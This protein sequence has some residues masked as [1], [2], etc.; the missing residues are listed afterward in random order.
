[1]E[2]NRDFFTDIT[3]QFKSGAKIFP[4]KI[5]LD[6]NGV[7]LDYQAVKRTV[8]ADKIW[9]IIAAELLKYD[10]TRIIYA[11]RG[12]RLV[13]EA[14]DKKVNMRHEDAL[15]DAPQTSVV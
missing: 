7:T 15:A 11:E 6:E 5:L 2:E 10:E 12:A 13:I 8:A 3:I 4:A 1:M 14:S 9:D